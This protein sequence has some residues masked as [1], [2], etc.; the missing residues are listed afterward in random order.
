MQEKPLVS[1]IIPAYNEE[2]YISGLLSSLA[3]Q[4]YPRLEVI[5]ADARSPD[6]TREIADSYGAKVV[7]G[8]RP[9]EGRN[10]GVAAASGE[11]LVF[12]DADVCVP[13][14]FLEK[15]VAAFENK[16]Y[17][18]AT[19]AFLPDSLLKI[20]LLMFRVAN[21]IMEINRWFYPMAPGFAIICTARIFRRIGGFDE[22]LKLAE[23]HDFVKRAKKL[24]AFG[25]I[26]HTHVTVS[27]RRLVKEGRLKLIKKY[28]LVELKRLFKGKIYDD[29]IGYEFGNFDR[30][31]L[32]KTEE[33][34]E[35]LLVEL[36]RIKSRKHTDKISDDKP[37]K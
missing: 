27:V 1:I 9:A 25:I 7:D 31:D 14:D 36:D 3:A 37:R 24:A 12:L 16:Y 34:L 22:A 13:P 18:V 21:S 6:R 30:A 35:R 28:S 20:D 33:R 4:T 17:E 29:M 11:Y 32:S 10:R 26:R 23:D 8:G 15:A 19:F 2:D 5:V